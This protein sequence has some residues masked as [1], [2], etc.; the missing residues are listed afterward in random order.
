MFHS[1]VFANLLFATAKRNEGLFSRFPRRQVKG[2]LVFLPQEDMK[3]IE[4]GT[5]R[6][7][8]RCLRDGPRPERFR[9]CMVNM[10]GG[11]GTAGNSTEDRMCIHSYD[12]IY[13]H[14]MSFHIYHI[15]I[16][17]YLWRFPKM[18][19]PPKSSKIGLFLGTPMYI[20]YIH[21]CDL[22]S[23]SFLRDNLSRLR[24]VPIIGDSTWEAPLFSDTGSSSAG[25][26]SNMIG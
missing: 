17:L 14:S 9:T 1:L 10:W 15:S 8:M 5:V 6:T 22:F 20:I 25:D 23:P 19:V 11:E 3:E 18:E 16:Y 2:E 21:T 24:Q 4:A 13:L 12:Y 26:I 7:M